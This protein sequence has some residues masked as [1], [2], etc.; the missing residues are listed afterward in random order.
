MLDAG[1][2]SACGGGEMEGGEEGRK[3]KRD[4]GRGGGREEE[5]VGRAR[6]GR[7]R[8][9]FV[10]LCMCVLVYVCD[11]HSCPPPTLKEI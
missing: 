3:G 8:E 11:T 9:T 5:E 7:G 1:K 2:Q 6:G 10:S 4:E